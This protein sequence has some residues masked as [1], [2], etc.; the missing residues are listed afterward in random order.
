MANATAIDAYWNFFRAFNTR[1]HYE[2]SAAM[3]Y[4]HVRMSWRADPVVLADAEAHALSVSWD[5][6]IAS[7]WDHTVGEQPLLIHESPQKC[8]IRGGWTR[9]TSENKPILSNKVCYIVTKL[10]DSWG[11]QCRF[12]T[13][14]GEETKNVS[15]DSPI[16]K[17]VRL[18]IESITSG[19]GHQT[20][21]SFYPTSYEIGVG[22]VAKV[23]E[24][25]QHVDHQLPDPEITPI[26]AGEHSATVAITSSQ[27]N[28]LLYLTDT[29]D[30]KIKAIS[31]V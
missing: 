20:L 7:G 8:H 24:A 13:D 15:E 3:Q 18:W 1:D 2:F 26:H 4:P 14:S 9:F 27:E 17:A 6:F 25:L 10:N 5:G 23:T 11:I 16:L 12:G 31:W 30:W 19:D 28:A 22:Q 21:S 29:E